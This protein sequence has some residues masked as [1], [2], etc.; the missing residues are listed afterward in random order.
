MEGEGH[1][2]LAVHSITLNC[3]CSLAIVRSMTSWLL[4]PQQLCSWAC[5][6]ILAFYLRFL[7]VLSCSCIGGGLITCCWN[8]SSLSS[9]SLGSSCEVK[10][11]C[12][13]AKCFR[14]V[15]HHTHNGEPF[16]CPF[17]SPEVC[18]VSTIF[19]RMRIRQWPSTLQSCHKIRFSCGLW[20]S[21][22]A[23]I[24]CSF[25]NTPTLHCAV[26]WPFASVYF[27]VCY[28]SL[29]M[30]ENKWSRNVTNWA[31]VTGLLTAMNQLIGS[32]AAS[33]LSCTE[34]PLRDL[35]SSWNCH[36]GYGAW[37]LIQK[38]RVWP[39]CSSCLSMEAKC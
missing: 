28:S 5:R 20:C 21:S 8:S 23:S 38:T 17:A 33:S 39:S 19:I 16:V 32:T 13:R 29:G 4:S 27:M 1:F 12:Y 22:S 3:G 34:L 18:A 2:Y 10:V 11:C 6:T 7:H 30:F 36:N 25:S 14:F 35:Y 26:R 31:D 24:T 37:L 15:N 9:N